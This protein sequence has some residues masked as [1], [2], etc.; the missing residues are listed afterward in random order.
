MRSRSM[1][2]DCAPSSRRRGCEYARCAATATSWSPCVKAERSVRRRLLAWLL[3]PLAMVLVASGIFTY[4]ASLK[5]A[6]DAYDRS[7]LDPALAIAGRLRVHGTAVELDLPASVLEALQVDSGDR[8][9]FSVS[10]NGR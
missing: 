7:L 9:F 10:T 3:V 1:S 4:Q 2:R 5:V 6:A 8:L